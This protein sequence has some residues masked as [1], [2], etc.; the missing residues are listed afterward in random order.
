MKLFN[1]KQKKSKNSNEEYNPLYIFEDREE[2]SP[3]DAQGN[4]PLHLVDKEHFFAWR[5]E[6]V[7]YTIENHCILI[8]GGYQTIRELEWGLEKYDD[9][10][11]KTADISA[12]DIKN[13]KN[14]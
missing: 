1:N 13:L 10:V 5:E 2:W 4:L 11:N 12:E 6:L 9:A 3:K 7:K 14:G 8:P